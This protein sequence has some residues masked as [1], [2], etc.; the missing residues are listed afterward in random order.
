MSV[1]VTFH[2]LTLRGFGPY[3]DERVVEFPSAMGVICAPNAAGK[4]SVVA[5]LIAVLYG[6]P[7]TSDPRDFGQTRYRNWDGSARFEGELE[8]SVESSDCHLRYRLLRDFNTHHVRLLR[9]EAQGAV[10][11]IDSAHNPSARRRNERY[12]DRL[13]AIL[14]IRSRELFLSTFCVA[15]PLPL[16][17][18]I[19]VE[20]QRLLSGAGAGAYP[21]ALDRLCEA[22]K[23][24]TVRTGELHV[25]PRNGKREGTLD[26]LQRRLA[27]LRQRLSSDADVA[28]RL[29]RIADELAR[30]GK[31]RQE[32]ANELQRAQALLQTWRE[33]RRH[34]DTYRDSFRRRAEIREAVQQAALMARRASEGRAEMQAAWPE[35][36]QFTDASMT[37]LLQLERLQQ[38]RADVMSRLHAIEIDMRGESARYFAMDAAIHGDWRLTQT[39]AGTCEALTRFVQASDALQSYALFERAAAGMPD[40]QTLYARRVVLVDDIARA[41]RACEDAIHQSNALE[42]EAASL[43][44]EEAELRPYVVDLDERLEAVRTLQAQ[45]ERAKM[46]QRRWL[47]QAVLSSATLIPVILLSFMATKG[48]ARLCPLAMLAIGCGLIWRAGA[49]ARG[50]DRAIRSLGRRMRGFGGSTTDAAELMRLS[51]QRG[52]L[53]TRQLLLQERRRTLATDE[54]LSDARRIEASALTE[55]EKLDAYLAPFE[56]HYTDVCEAERAWV[57]CKAAVQA[58]ENA[59]REERAALEARL[60]L[61]KQQKQQEE[62]RHADIQQQIEQ[63]GASV[64]V[65]LEAC[66]GDASLARERLQAFLSARATMVADEQALV[67]TLSAFGDGTTLS[68]LRERRDLTDDALQTARRRLA[69]LA[70][71][72]AELPEPDRALEPATGADRMAELQRQ[73]HDTESQ[74]MALDEQHRQLEREYD[75][76]FD[77]DPLNVAAAE[78][79]LEALQREEMTRRTEVEAISLAWHELRAAVADYQSSH[80]VRLEQAASRYFGPL[81]GDSGATVHLDA[82][83]SVRVRLTNGH[84]ILPQQLSCG[85]QDQLYVALRLAVADLLAG[86]QCLPLIFDDPFVNFDDDRLQRMRVALQSAAQTRQVLLFTHRLDASAWG[87]PVELMAGRSAELV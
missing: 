56:A 9:L 60:R 24:R 75:R 10:T 31:R 82:T 61:H 51:Q 16:T 86:E 59:V 4:S 39:D 6:L 55:L 22:L 23:L 83:F 50:I 70:E 54:A 52:H 37:T 42:A 68:S 28:D 35:H 46:A 49:E 67:A 84:E 13:H 33:W 66:K 27:E 40:A 53:E 63:L 44:T 3:R 80:R 25:T 12:E 65:L 87:E 38:E 72:C 76:L 47:R 18:C 1:R 19:D 64:K 8:L 17:G 57:G 71:T 85:T 48:W 5:G 62:L 30:M 79:E 73:V 69:D 34:A 45:R 81:S 29:H 77:R 7:S 2:R 11:E 20:L 43:E 26:E 36:A 41:R 32:V 78:V 74:S 21:A 14:G 58:A 15:Q